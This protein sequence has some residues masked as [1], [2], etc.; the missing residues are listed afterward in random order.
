M[1]L[2]PPVFLAVIAAC[3]ALAIEAPPDDA[4]PPAESPTRD[5]APA[6]PAIQ[7]AYLGVV[8][9]ALPEMLAEH[10]GLAAG[11]GVLVQA[12][13]PDG[14]AAKA[15]LAVHDLITRIDGNPVASSADLSRE[16][17]KRRPGQQVRLDVIHKGKAA[18]VDA[19]LEARPAGLAAPP[20]PQALNELNLDGIPADLA[21]RIRRMIEGNVGEM[22]LDPERDE[23][24][25]VPPIEDAMRDMRRQMQDMLKQ[26]FELPKMPD[27]PPQ[28]GIQIHQGATF[29]LMDDE[30][31]I[32]MK[33]ND[34]GKEIT[35]RDK[36]D[37]IVWTGPWD[38]E[39]D[40]AAAPV[41]IRRR[42]DRLDFDRNGNGLRFQFRGGAIPVPE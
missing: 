23:G 20:A 32:E 2:S 8:A 39:Q 27:L 30:G 19:T 36:D 25:A 7:P 21:D 41:D 13:T 17:G 24:L 4:P 1:K 6:V 12:L 38:T 26:P 14:P 42:I 10:L 33:S 29:R 3:P 31:S 18:A 34:D 40:K 22:K 16:V 35:V 37:K 15:G 5:A 9:V 11:D 28:G